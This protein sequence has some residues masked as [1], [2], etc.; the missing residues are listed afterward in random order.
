MVVTRDWGLEEMGGNV[1]QMVQTFNYKVNK[2]WGSNVQR[3]IIIVNTGLY[4]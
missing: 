1:G 4:N 2:F 3:I